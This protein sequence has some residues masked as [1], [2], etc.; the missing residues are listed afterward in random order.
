MLTVLLVNNALSAE[1]RLNSIIRRIG[2]QLVDQAGTLAAMTPLLK[3]QPLT[4][5]LIDLPSQE[6]PGKNHSQ[7][8]P[9]NLMRLIPG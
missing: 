9:C 2:G 6:S 1:M 7:T 4:L 5:V 3:L 8:L